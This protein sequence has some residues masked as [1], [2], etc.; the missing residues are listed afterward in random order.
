VVPGEAVVVIEILDGIDAGEG[1][2][3]V[4]KMRL[5]VVT[6]VQDQFAP[7][8]LLTAGNI[9]QHGLEAADAAKH[10]RR[11]A[12]VL[13]E[14]FDEAAGAESGFGGDFGNFYRGGTR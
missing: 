5:V 6:A 13:F 8:N 7:A 2:E 12:Y 1:A 14:E 4:D 10:F 3:V 11:H 9:F